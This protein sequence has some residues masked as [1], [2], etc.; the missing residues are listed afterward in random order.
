MLQLD[1]LGNE[2]ERS[3]GRWSVFVRDIASGDVLFDHHGAAILSTASVGKL[4][5]LAFAGN[6]L[7][8]HPLSARTLLDRRAVAPV[9]DS[10]LWQHLGLDRLTI[11]DATRLVFA[12][13]DNLAS[14][15]LLAHFGLDHVRA[16]RPELDLQHTDL[17]D[18][19]RDARSRDDPEALSCGP[20]VEL[21]GFMMRLA[22]GELVSP[23]LSRW[24]REGLSLNMDLSMVPAGLGLDPLTRPGDGGRI[25]VA[26]KTGTDRGVRADTG[27][28]AC[29]PREIAYAAVCNYDDAAVSDA[30]VL[31]TIRCIGDAIVSAQ[32]RRAIAVSSM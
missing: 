9:G 4:I 2:L 24:L 28:V 23:S 1:E 26:N 14:N 15:A 32:P 10:G 25:R 20:A 11:A 27:I 12:A 5:L 17:F 31:D 22:R 6:E 16:F 29:G 7:L 30:S 18:F 21:C 8:S 13:S 3:P 19:V